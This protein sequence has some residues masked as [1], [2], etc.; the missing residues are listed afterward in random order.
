MALPCVAALHAMSLC[1]VVPQCVADQWDPQGVCPCVV[2]V[3]LKEAAVPKE[4]V[5]HLVDTNEEADIINEVNYLLYLC[6]LTSLVILYNLE[7]Y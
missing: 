1:G 6:Y 7:R 4:V 3:A 5:A 2:V